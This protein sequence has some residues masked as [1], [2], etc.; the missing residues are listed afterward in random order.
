MIIDVTLSPIITQFGSFQLSWA[1]VFN[2]LGMIL[3]LRLGWSRARLRSISASALRNTASW[4]IFGGLLGARFFA[5][6]EHLPYY[7]ANPTEILAIADGSVVSWG[8]WLGGIAA[9]VIVASRQDLPIWECLD[10]AAPALLLGDAVG[11]VGA[12][13]SGERWGTPT[14]GAWGIIYWNPQDVLPPSLLGIP[15]H[16]YPL[17]L[18]AGLLA[19]CVILW[20]GRPWLAT[21]HG[22]RFIATLFLYSL[23]RLGLAPFHAATVLIGGLSA[24]QLYPFGGVAIAI[25]LAIVHVCVARAPREGGR[26]DHDAHPQ[27]VAEAP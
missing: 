23:L 12:L 9:G 17:Y 14:G 24:E 8:A 4:A 27:H 22:G 10:V 18:M 5:I 13:I 1:G 25:A 15:L 26:V 11:L 2:T 6:I 3:G 7:R 19:I 16:P 20:I 21:R